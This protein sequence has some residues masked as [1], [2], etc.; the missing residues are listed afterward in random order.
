M[1]PF[2][3]LPLGGGFA[4]TFVRFASSGQLEVFLNLNDLI[5][6]RLSRPAYG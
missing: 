1:N 3:L 2:P 6:V 5:N 4:F